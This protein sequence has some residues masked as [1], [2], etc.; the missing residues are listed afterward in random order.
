MCDW[1][2]TRYVI[3]FDAAACSERIYACVT[4]TKVALTLCLRLFTALRNIEGDK[5]DDAV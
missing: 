3:L 5:N 1:L 4:A 2:I